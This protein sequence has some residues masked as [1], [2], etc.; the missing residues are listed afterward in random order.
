M[1]ALFRS[2]GESPPLPA[3]ILKDAAATYRQASKYDRRD[4]NGLA[5]DAV[6]AIR[7]HQLR[8]NDFKM[9]RTWMANATGGVGDVLIVFGPEDV[10]RTTA[11]LLVVE[12]ENLLCRDDAIVVVGGFGLGDVLQSRG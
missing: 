6:T 10:C 9:A 7:R 3:V 8:D 1:P 5:L 2:A 11:A 4:R 12:W